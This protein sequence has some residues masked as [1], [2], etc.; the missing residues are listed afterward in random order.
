MGGWGNA[1]VRLCKRQA[2]KGK[3]LLPGGGL[4]NVGGWGNAVV[5]L[6]KRQARKGKGLLPGG[7]LYNQLKE[8]CFGISYVGEFNPQDH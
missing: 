1:V 4:D 6:C 5:R 2:R 7:G 8:F 3:G